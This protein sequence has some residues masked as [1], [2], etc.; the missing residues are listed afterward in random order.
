MF[1]ILRGHVLIIINQ[2][3]VAT[4]KEGQY[5]GE[6]AMIAQIPRTATVAAGSSCILCMFGL[7]QSHLRMY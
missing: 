2:V 5:F 4:L 7:Q 1:F 6:V 3:Q